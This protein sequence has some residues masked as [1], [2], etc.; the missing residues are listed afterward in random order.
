VLLVD[1]PGVDSWPLTA[2]TF[3]LM[4]SRSQ[5]STRA[6]EVL[7]FFHWAYHEGASLAREMGYVPL[8]ESLVATV[9]QSWRRQFRTSDGGYLWTG[10]EAGPD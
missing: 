10:D 6:L 3:I 9:E 2:A 1:V 8:P 4:P 5:D 7:R